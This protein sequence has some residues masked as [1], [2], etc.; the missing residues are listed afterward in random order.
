MNFL[1]TLLYI[2]LFIFCLSVLVVVH[3]LGHFAAAKFFK[4]YCQEFSI[5]FGPA[6]IK[7][8]RKNGETYFSF[9][10]FPFGG[11]VSMYGEGVEL[12]EGVD[13]D[14]SRSFTALKKWKRIIILFAGVF[15]NAILALILFLISESCF[16]QKAMYLNYVNVDAGSVAETIGITNEDY[17]SLRQYSYESEGKTVNTNYYVVD[18]EA[19]VTYND[20]TTK[21][22]YA[23]LDLSIP[24]YTSRSYDDALKFYIKNNSGFANLGNEITAVDNNVKGVT[25]N[26]TT[27][28]GAYKQY[29][30]STWV[31]LP[32]A[33]IE[34]PRKGEAYIDRINKT[35]MKWNGS[36]WKKTSSDKSSYTEPT[37]KEEFYI[38]YDLENETFKH[39]LALGTS[40]R[41]D[42]RVFEACGL[43]FLYEEYWN[44]A[45]QVASKTFEDFGTSSTAIVRGLASLF[46]S[47]E[48]W[49]DVGGVVAIGVQTTNI[50]QNFGLGKFIYIWG[51]ISVN[52]AIVNLLPYPGL[53]GWQIVVL[54]VEGVFHKDIPDRVKNI[55][56]LIGLAILFSFMILI[57]IKDVIGLF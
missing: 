14:P 52:L 4:V 28:K 33:P 42:T 6:L 51:L 25:Y 46:T 23:L 18:K 37:E 31:I 17:I 13:V 54:V 32:E 21:E 30:D 15:N 45:G 43:S 22:V 38:W 8:K 44:N 3:E 57:L 34:S 50:L 19:Y 27:A 47:T 55:V 5:G 7:K 9:R 49:K 1:Y 48:S 40:S 16:I 35:L 24:T 29:I 41:N 26:V 10:A 20:D 39:E 56:S 12:P 11:Y 2:I 36:E 53:D